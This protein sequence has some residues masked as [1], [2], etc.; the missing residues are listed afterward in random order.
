M[1]VG[2]SDEVFEGGDGFEEV[3]VEFF[4][5]DCFAEDVE[6]GWGGLSLVYVLFETSGVELE[7]LGV[8]ALD[9]EF[10]EAIFDRAVWLV[11]EELKGT[12]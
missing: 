8:H 10:R 2:V 4:E 12:R 5:L 1:G 7:T 6:H 3:A 11:M 9:Q